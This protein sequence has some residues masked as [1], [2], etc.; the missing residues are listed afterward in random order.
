MSCPPCSPPPWP[1]RTKRFARSPRPRWTNCD[2]RTRRPSRFAA[3]QLKDSVY[4]ETALRRAGRLGVSALTAALKSPDAA[5]RLKAARTL[6]SLGE[7]ATEAGPALTAVLS[8]KDLEIRLTAAKSLWN[9]SKQ[10]EAVVPVLIQLLEDKRGADRDDPEV[11]RRFVQTVM[12]ALWRIGPPAKSA[13]PALMGKTKD[14][15]RLIRESAAEAVRRI[16][17]AEAK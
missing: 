10:T 3:K 1:T 8:D 17:P 9:V 5:T 4:A 13:L 7:V 11:R 2:S 6:G 15:N 16:G 12:E 14:P